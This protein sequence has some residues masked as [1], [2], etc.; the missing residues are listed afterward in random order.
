MD[1]AC[2]H[3]SPAC[4]ECVTN[5][6]YVESFKE[7]EV[8]PR[9]FEAEAFAALDKITRPGRHAILVWCESERFNTETEHGEKIVKS[10]VVSSLDHKHTLDIMKMMMA[11]APPNEA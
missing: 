4:A 2:P 5:K 10:T 7:A 3:G 8:S 11:A 9:S 6:K 1:S